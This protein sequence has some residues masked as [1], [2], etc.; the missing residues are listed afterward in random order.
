[1]RASIKRNTEK[2]LSF[3][4][5]FDVKADDDGG[6]KNGLC[7]RIRVRSTIVLE[8]D[9]QNVELSL[10]SSCGRFASFE[11][12]QQVSMR[13][14]SNCGSEV[15]AGEVVRLEL[16]TKEETRPPRP[17]RPHCRRLGRAAAQP[18][19]HRGP[20]RRTLAFAVSDGSRR[21]AAQGLGS[22]RHPLAGARRADGLP[23]LPGQRLHGHVP[24]LLREERQPV[25]RGPLRREV[26]DHVSGALETRSQNIKSSRRGRRERER[27][28]EGR[29]RDGGDDDKKR[30]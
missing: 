25:P 11:L 24:L 5:P 23:L 7:L 29:G 12:R 6:K 1:M 21:G 16:P 30:Q 18:A 22:R 10:P 9:R 27:A 8:R 19:K 13:S 26:Q 14:D 20:A 17:L 4:P 28:R 3:F 15:T 2:F